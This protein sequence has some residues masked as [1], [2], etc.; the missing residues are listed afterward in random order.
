VTTLVAAGA[1]DVY[2]HR[3]VLS[4]DD[5]GLF[6]VGF[7]TALVSAL[8]VVRWLI[9]YV[10]RHDFRPFAWYRIAFGGIVLVTAYTGLVDWTL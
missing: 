6:G 9:R 8:V 10:A 7:V 1:Y 4:A 2:R 5:A 3:D